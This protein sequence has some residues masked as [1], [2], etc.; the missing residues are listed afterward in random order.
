MDCHFSDRKTMGRPKKRHREDD[1]TGRGG[2][3]DTTGNGGA[4]DT[5]QPLVFDPHLLST[6]GTS[7]VDALP[8]EHANNMA[9]SLSMPD[10]CPAIPESS[11]NGSHKTS[12]PQ[13]NL[14]VDGESYHFAEPDLTVA[15]SPP[16][17]DV[18]LTGI[19]CSCLSELYSMLISFQSLPSPSFPS[20][21]APLTRA[22]NLA[23]AVV[24]CPFCPRDFP[25]ALQNLMLL[26]TLLPLV[27]HGYAQVL[28][29]VHE[30]AT[31]GRRITYRVGDLAQ[32]GSQ[33]HT[34]TPDCPLGFN[35]E[36]DSEE[37]AAMA[38]K[39][40]KQ[41]IYGNGQSIDCLL[42]VVEELEQRQH[43][44]HLLQ[45]FGQHA[46]C[47]TPQSDD[48]HEHNPVCLQLTGHIRGAINALHL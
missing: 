34:G 32:A 12:A 1:P 40:L 15:A 28:A 30:E 2:G 26:T 11:V 8:W 18:H 45:P 6:T 20:S 44:W 47:S 16:P 43:I 9:L 24:R 5:N 10:D 23:R 27:V 3:I 38:R 37:W 21:R 42:S 19:T 13:T 4:G 41:D 7:T 39:V 29:V 35:V 17:Q 48:S 14:P 36:L 31:Q 33:L 22:I 25:S 46:S